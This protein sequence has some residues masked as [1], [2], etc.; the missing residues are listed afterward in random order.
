MAFK[1]THYLRGHSLEQMAIIFDGEDAQVLPSETAEITKETL[2][3]KNDSVQIEEHA[4]KVIRDVYI[5][6]I[7]CLGI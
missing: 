2:K 3:G 1:L 5:A 4:W 6:T 7:R